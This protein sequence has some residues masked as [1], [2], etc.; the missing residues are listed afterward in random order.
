M[1]TVAIGSRS[2]LA[3]HVLDSMQRF[4]DQVFLQRDGWSL[5]PIP[6]MNAAKRDEYDTAEAVYLVVTDESCRVTASARLLASTGPYMLR[7]SFPELLG[8]NPAPSDPITWE[9]SRFVTATGPGTGERV[10]SLPAFTLDLLALVA[11]AGRQRSARRIILPTTVVV[12][13]LLMRAHVDVHR[14]APPESVD[15]A[16]CVALMLEV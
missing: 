4:H 8:G 14:F 11:E 15:G 1:R 5:Q 9:L 10:R 16:L 12:E 3:P 2:Q 6:R 7:S 13:R